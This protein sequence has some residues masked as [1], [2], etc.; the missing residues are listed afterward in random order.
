[1]DLMAG[2][3]PHGYDNRDLING[4][5]KGVGGYWEWLI[6]EGQ[7]GGG[8]KHCQAVIKKGGKVLFLWHTNNTSI[9]TN[10]NAHCSSCQD[11]VSIKQQHASSYPWASKL[12]WCCRPWFSGLWDR[13]AHTRSVCIWCV[14]KNAPI[15]I[16][17]WRK[18]TRYIWTSANIL[19]MNYVEQRLGNPHADVKIALSASPS[20]LQDVFWNHLEVPGFDTYFFVSELWA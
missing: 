20:E 3:Q 4:H 7:R 12:R 11:Q 19:Y 2:T 17:W 16:I 10:L 5:L 18:M 14:K 6:V 1:M 13:P 15:Y 9:V 8:E